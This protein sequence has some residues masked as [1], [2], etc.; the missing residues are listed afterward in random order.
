MGAK[1]DHSKPKKCKTC[2]EVKLPE[3][4]YSKSKKNPTVKIASCKVCTDK[5]AVQIRLARTPEQVERDRIRNK[6]WQEDN[7]ERVKEHNDRSSLRKFGLSKEDFE[8][9]KEL[10]NNLCDICKNPETTISNTSKLRQI[11]RL[12]VDHCH[13]SGKVRGLLCATCNLALGKF[14]DSIE[15]LQNAINYLKRHS[16]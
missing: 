2:E 15:T 9:M 3:E 7:F 1:L 14:K 13:T 10:Q 5:K 11:N 16:K 4:F 8:K 6:K 12:A